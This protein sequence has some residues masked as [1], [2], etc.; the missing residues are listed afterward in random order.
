MSYVNIFRTDSIIIPAADVPLYPSTY[1]FFCIFLLNFTLPRPSTILILT[2]LPSPP[3]CLPATCI[4]MERVHFYLYGKNFSARTV[5][6]CICIL[7]TTPPNVTT[8]RYTHLNFSF[9]NKIFERH[10]LHLH[11]YI[12]V[13]R[14]P[15]YYVFFIHVDGRVFLKICLQIYYKMSEFERL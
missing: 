3:I 6:K 14:R 8:K 11:N 10:E 9:S 5:C 7:S 4:H 13:H 2:H 12:L 15:H 1:V